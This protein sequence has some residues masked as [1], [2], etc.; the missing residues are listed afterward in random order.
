MPWSRVRSH[1]KDWLGSERM[2]WSKAQITPSICHFD[3]RKSLPYIYQTFHLKRKK[4]KTTK[5]LPLLKKRAK[6]Q[7]KTP[8]SPFSHVSINA[9]SY[10]ADF[11]HQLHYWSNYQCSWCFSQKTNINKTTKEVFPLYFPFYILTICINDQILWIH[12]YYCKKLEE[13]LA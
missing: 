2:I 4:K 5:I 1:N 3:G 7:L 8:V 6:F 10:Y 13:L 12:M 9:L 11:F